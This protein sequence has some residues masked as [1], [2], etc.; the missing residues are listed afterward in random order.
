MPAPLNRFPTHHG[1][2][3]LGLSRYIV[4]Y[5]A[6][7]G[8]VIL[9]IFLYWDAFWPSSCTPEGLLETYACSA[10]LPENGGWREAALLTWLWSTPLLIALDL[11]RCFA[12]RRH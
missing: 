8:W 5:L 3:E 4:L 12:P 9:G 6:Q 11:L 7:A 1:H 10:Q 2:G